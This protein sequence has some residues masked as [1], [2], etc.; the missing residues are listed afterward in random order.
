MHKHTLFKTDENNKKEK[1][2]RGNTTPPELEEILNISEPFNIPTD[3]KEKEPEEAHTLALELEEKPKIDE[4][5]HTNVTSISHVESWLLRR[6]HKRAEIAEGLKFKLSEAATEKL[7]P[8]WATILDCLVTE[9][10]MALD[11]DKIEQALTAFSASL[12]APMQDAVIRQISFI[13]RIQKSAGTGAQLNLT[14]ENLSLLNLSGAKLAS[15]ILTE[16]DLTASYLMDADL[17]EANLTEAD[18]TGANLTRANLTEANLTKADLTGAN[19]AEIILTGTILTGVNLAN[20]N[21]AGQNLTN[22][23]LTGVNLANADLTDANLTG[24][25]LTKAIL[26]SPNFTRAK[27]GGAKLVDVF[28]NEVVLTE[29]DLTGVDLTGAS[30]A[31]NDF[32]TAILVDQQSQQMADLSTCRCIF[33]LEINF[34]SKRDKNFKW[35]VLCIMSL[36]QNIWSSDKK[37]D[38]PLVQQLLEVV[39]RDIENIVSRLESE[40]IRN[41]FEK[42]WGKGQ[43][44]QVTTIFQS[45]FESLNNTLEI[46][47]QEQVQKF[48]Q[49]A[50]TSNILGS[51]ESQS[52]HVAEEKSLDFF[53]QWKHA[54]A[55]RIKELIDRTLAQAEKCSKLSKVPDVME[56]GSKENDVS[57]R[58]GL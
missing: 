42:N 5:F 23:D 33:P 10:I 13:E 57:H 58:L 32:S 2:K 28:M 53:Y 19:L 51:D 26:L 31:M 49:L 52:F 4:S 20:A 29:T 34:D 9:N 8:N 54:I 40:S 27:L 45:V 16:V 21:L 6:G 35:A 15:A 17:T 11:I 14:G 30:L 50:P 7:D 3:E 18:L 47:M 36:M 24:A 44:F 22:V 55:P 12:T 1:R 48:A 38:K 43:S 25:D 56:L 37:P 41:H 46:F 39:I